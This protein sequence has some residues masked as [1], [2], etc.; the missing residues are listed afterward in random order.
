MLFRSPNPNPNPPP[1]P[2]PNPAPQPQPRTNVTV[3]GRQPEPD[4]VDSDPETRGLSDNTKAEM[5]AGRTTVEQYERRNDAEFDAGQQNLKP[6]AN[7]RKR[8]PEE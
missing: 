1:P 3:P 7:D 8:T 2:T 5:E 4:I 6:Y